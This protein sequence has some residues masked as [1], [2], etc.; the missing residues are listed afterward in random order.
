LDSKFDGKTRRIVFYSSDFI[1]PAG[2]IVR[3]SPAADYLSERGLVARLFNSYGAR[4]GNWEVMAR[5]TFAHPRLKNALSKK[6]KNK[7][8]FFVFEFYLSHIQLSFII[9]IC[10]KTNSLRQ[11]RINFIVLSRNNTHFLNFLT[12][13]NL[14]QYVFAKASL[15]ALVAA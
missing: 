5:G 7:D 9:N 8:I 13:P 11:L 6:V 3:N 12:N 10:K 1:S 14:I 4:R 2:S 15:T